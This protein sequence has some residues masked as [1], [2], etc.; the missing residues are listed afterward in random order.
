MSVSIS[1]L[2]LT[3]TLFGTVV[4]HSYIKQDF[5]LH[6]LSLNVL[7]FSILNHSINNIIINKIDIFFAHTLASYSIYNLYIIMNP[8]IICSLFIV[9]LWIIECKTTNKKLAENLHCLIHIT[10]IIGMHGYLLTNI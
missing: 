1:K 2:Q 5:Y 8:F 4:F 7:I 3:S 6:L 10:A 9:F